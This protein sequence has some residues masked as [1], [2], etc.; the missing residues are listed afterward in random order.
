MFILL[1]QYVKH[2]QFETRATIY[3]HVKPTGGDCPAA[4]YQC[5]GTNPAVCLTSAKMCDG[6]LHCHDGSDEDLAVC[7]GV[8]LNK[9]CH[10]EGKCSI[11]HLLESNTIFCQAFIDIFCIILLWISNTNLRSSVSQSG[12]RIIFNRRKEIISLRPLL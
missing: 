7:L 3:I 5:P 6:I 8:H 2:E 9:I 12:I 1:S 10:A 4:G 11:Y